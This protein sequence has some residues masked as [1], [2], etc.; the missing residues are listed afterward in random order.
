MLHAPSQETHGV[1]TRE[2]GSGLSKT[3]DDLLEEQSKMERW[4]GDLV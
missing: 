3:V 2:Y 4:V 1:D